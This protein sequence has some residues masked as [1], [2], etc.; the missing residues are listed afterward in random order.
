MT[1]SIFFRLVKHNLDQYNYMIIPPS[2]MSLQF[3]FIE[4]QKWYLYMKFPYLHLH[5]LC[6]RYPY[7]LVGFWKS[8]LVAFFISRASTRCY[9]IIRGRGTIFG[10]GTNRKIKKKKKLMPDL[11]M[12]F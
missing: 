7:R 8:K 3:F 11:F 4:L 10:L 12:K 9:R 5:V 6:I 1:F 2:F